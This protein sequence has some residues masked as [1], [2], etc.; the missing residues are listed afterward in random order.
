MPLQDI[1]ALPTAPSRS[2]AP[3]VFIDRADAFVA[4][5]P[6]LVTEINTLGDQLELTAALINA[7]PAYAD[8]GLVALTGLT[9]AADKVPYWTGATTSA[10]MTFTSVA[11]TLVGQ[12]S[13]A[14]MRTTGLGM[15]AD[16]SSLTAAAN[17]A[18]MKALLDLESGM[19]FLSPAAIAA[20]YQPLDTD[21][22]AIAGLTSAAD[23][24]P[25]FTGSGTAALMTVTT[26]A[27]TV[28]DD[29]TT[30][31][32]L[33]TLDAQAALTT[34]SNGNGYWIAIIIGATTFYYQ[35]GRITAAANGSSTITFP[36]A[37]TTSASI[38]VTGSGVDS[39]GG[40]G[41]Q[42]N[43]PAVSAY[44][45]TTATVFSADETSCTYHWQA[46]GY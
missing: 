29:S 9:A 22:T 23:A 30:A 34:G 16:G 18:A 15:S 8:A 44:S 35:W 24:A 28:L 36:Q 25:Y 40:T 3:D 19:D 11:R 13:Q 7:A 5:L 33:T 45:T 31:A 37:F 42:D 4:A 43:P 21:L 41:A 32:M 12:S 27:R 6:G 14:N 10:T 39:G 17:Y 1:T 2:D 20:A 26:A 46:I 38:S